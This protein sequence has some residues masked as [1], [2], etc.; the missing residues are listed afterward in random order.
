[1]LFHELKSLFAQIKRDI[2]CP[3]CKCGY[4]DNGIKLLIAFNDECYMQMTCAS[5]NTQAYVSAIINR[6]KEQR[7]HQDLKIRNMGAKIGPITVNEV[8]DVHNFLQ[9]FDGNFKS[10]FS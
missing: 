9:T 6:Y 5:C 1:M 8:I 4:A 2:R 10:L 3:K 7:S